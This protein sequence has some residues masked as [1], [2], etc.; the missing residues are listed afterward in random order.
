MLRQAAG[1]AEETA[2]EVPP[3]AGWVPL[4]CWA[5]GELLE[6]MGMCPRG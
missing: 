6:F 5:V 4:R 2:S 1:A 3:R